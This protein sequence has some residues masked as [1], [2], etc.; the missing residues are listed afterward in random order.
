MKKS[1]K[2]KTFAISETDSTDQKLEKS[3][4]SRFSA[5]TALLEKFRPD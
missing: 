1:T 4:W 5:L 3:F 2:E